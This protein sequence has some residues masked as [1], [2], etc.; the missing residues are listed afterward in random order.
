[1]P[2]GSAFDPKYVSA[3]VSPPTGLELL[4]HFTRGFATRARL[5]R[6]LRRWSVDDLKKIVQMKRLIRCSHSNSDYVAIEIL[7]NILSF[8]M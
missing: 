1:V 8:W 4:A 3:W 6:A 5:V 7:D 2:F